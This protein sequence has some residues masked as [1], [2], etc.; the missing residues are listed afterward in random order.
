MRMTAALV[1]ALLVVAVIGFAT[2]HWIVGLA[3][4]AALP[5]VPPPPYAPEDAH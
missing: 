5:F 2:H 4:L 1:T 3:C